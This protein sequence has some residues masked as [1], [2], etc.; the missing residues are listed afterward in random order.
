MIITSAA[1]EVCGSFNVAKANRQAKKLLRAGQYCPPSFLERAPSEPLQIINSGTEDSTAESE[2]KVTRILTKIKYQSVPGIPPIKGF[3]V[4][5]QN[6]ADPLQRAVTNWHIDQQLGVVFGGTLF[7][8][9]F[10]KGDV[11]VSQLLDGFSPQDQHEKP[12]N[13]LFSS[14]PELGNACV[15]DALARGTAEILPPAKPGT[16]LRSAE[17]D[18]HRSFIPPEFEMPTNLPR[19]AVVGYFA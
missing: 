1:P 19:L 12:L 9:Q 18:I 16:L 11:D 6:I 15:E 7:S 10:I 3:A 4:W 8:P 2:A 5:I 17:H 14:K 13:Q